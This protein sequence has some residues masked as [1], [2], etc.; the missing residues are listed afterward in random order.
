MYSWPTSTTF[1]AFTMASA[2][3]IEPVSPRV[4]TIPSASTFRSPSR[5]VTARLAGECSIRPDEGS[6]APEGGAGPD[7]GSAANIPARAARPG[8]RGLGVLL[9]QR[10]RAEPAGDGRLLLRA[11]GR[12]DG[13]ERARVHRDLERPAHVPE[14]APA[15]LAHRPLVRP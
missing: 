10:P 3:S 14:P 7:G 8:P 11:Q 2:A 15:D 1:A 4:S 13:A 5:A 12:G 6:T 9:R